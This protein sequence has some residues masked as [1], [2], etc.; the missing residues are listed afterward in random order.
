MA[1]K[2]Y[3]KAHFILFQLSS[4]KYFWKYTCFGELILN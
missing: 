2:Y 1:Y 4:Q 3:P